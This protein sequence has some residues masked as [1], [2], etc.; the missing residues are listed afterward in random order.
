VKVLK[1]LVNIINKIKEES[2]NNSRN[3]VVIAC[4]QELV[5]TAEYFEFFNFCLVDL[6][7]LRW[8]MTVHFK[9]ENVI[10]TLS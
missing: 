3:T 5:L 9:L 10:K 8:F 7:C 1:V 6:D 4:V 2:N